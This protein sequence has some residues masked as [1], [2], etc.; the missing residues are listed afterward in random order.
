MKKYIYTIV[1]LATMLAS[2]SQDAELNQ[3]VDNQQ[4]GIT[5][6]CPSTEVTSRAAVDATNNTKVLWQAVDDNRWDDLSVFGASSAAGGSMFS[7]TEE[8]NDRST[9]TFVLELGQPAISTI[10][11][12]M[13]PYQ[14]TATWDNT[15]KKLTCEIPA[16][17]TPTKGSF[18]RKAAIMYNIGNET[19]PALRFAVNF[20]KVTVT[21]TNVHSICIS[22]TAPIAGKMDIT[23]SA[24]TPVTGATLNN[25]ALVAGEFQV[26][27]P[28]IYYIAVKKGDIPSP[29]ISYTYYND[30][31][32]ATVKTKAGASDI[33]F[34]RY[35]NVMPV[36]VDFS[37][38]NITTRN[39]IQLY[40]RSPYFAEFNVGST[41]TDYAQA[42]GDYTLDASNGDS[43]VM[44]G[45]Y[46]WGC[47]TDVRVL[48]H[49]VEEFD[50]FQGT[51]NPADLTLP[52]YNDV[53][54]A[55][56]GGI[57]KTPSS[58]EI[59]GL[60]NGV[61]TYKSATQR[62]LYHFITEDNNTKEGTDVTW[63]RHKADSTN[64]VDG[65]R[66][67]GFRITGRSEGYT[68]NHIFMPYTGMRRY[69][70]PNSEDFRNGFYCWTSKCDATQDVICPIYFQGWQGDIDGK[71][72]VV[73]R[74]DMLKNA[75]N[76][77]LDTNHTNGGR[78]Y[79]VRA[80]LR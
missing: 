24:I 17:Q 40:D 32:T 66:L 57:W 36:S 28:G 19:A 55:S 70:K 35:K 7:V 23:S 41:I 9:G 29:S 31:H 5:Q 68:Q 14:A 75:F 21:E 1:A 50:L 59:S 45:L 46:G 44:G 10:T 78:A 56:W 69:G 37:T 11:A 62:Q 33:T 65:C 38:G 79:A 47:L 51:I 4:E 6:V 72:Y 13:Y 52:I 15:N 76:T 34:A 12:M 80:V 48:G 26:I 64:Y 53:A 16:V 2:C 27:E 63:Y 25:V 30:N 74:W 58:D 20:L 67:S 42:T 54:S 8:S 49:N 43:N 22:S 3:V 77:N 18:D 73:F 71:D 61:T 60:F 39:A